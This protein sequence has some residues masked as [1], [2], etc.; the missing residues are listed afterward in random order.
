MH[1]FQYLKRLETEP[2][3]EESFTLDLFRLLSDED[4]FAWPLGD[5]GLCVALAVVREHTKQRLNSQNPEPKT[6]DDTDGADWWKR[7][8]NPPRSS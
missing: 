4:G 8:V 2:E 5:L 6:F 7:G 1:F 3:L